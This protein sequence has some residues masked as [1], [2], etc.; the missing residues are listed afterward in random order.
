MKGGFPFVPASFYCQEYR[1]THVREN[2]EMFLYAVVA[3][4]LPFVLG[5][6][7]LVVGVAV[8]AMLA[9][10]AFNL[11]GRRLLPIIILPSIGAYFAGLIFGASSS[12]LLYMIPAIWVGN[13]LFVF[14]IKE[15]A[16]AK[17]KNRLLSLG[18]ASLAKS[19]F[20]FIA[21]FALYSPSL[22]PAAFLTAFGA[23]QL[24]TALGGSAAALGLQE[25]KRRAGL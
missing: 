24:I 14:G 20:L 8:N 1:L 10:S 9:L 15:L 17:G 21:A 4:C 12:A 25:M 3:A 7:Q 11:T 5:H 13:A 2:V 22:V 16:L 18:A 19:I 23:F 6:Q